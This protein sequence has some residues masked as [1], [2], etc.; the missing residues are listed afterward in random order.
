MASL[1]AVAIVMAMA[2]ILPGSPMRTRQRTKK[3]AVQLG[4]ISIFYTVE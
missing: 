2:I 4:Y 3:L 1:M